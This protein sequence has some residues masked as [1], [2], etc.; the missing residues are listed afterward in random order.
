MKAKKILSVLLFIL[1]VFQPLVRADDF[2]PEEEDGVTETNSNI[3]IL[4]ADNTNGDIQVQFGLALSEYLKWN[5]INARFELSDSLDLLGSELINAR[6]ENLAVA[7]ICD[8]ASKGRMYHD[9]I[10]DHTYVC[11]GTNWVQID[12]GAGGGTV[13]DSTLG[14]FVDT[15]G[16]T[17]INTAAPTAVPFDNEVRKDT[18]ITHDNVTNNTRI[19]LDNAGWYQASYNISY[20]SGDNARKTLRCILQLNGTTMIPGSE[21]FSYSRNNVDKNG[22][23]SA[24]VAFETTGTNEYYE[25][26]CNQ[27]GSAGPVTLTPNGSGTLVQLLDAGS[28]GGGVPFLDMSGTY[29]IAPSTTDTISFYG[30]SFSPNMIVSFPSF[31]G[32]I[33]STNVISPTQVDVNITSTAITGS[34]DVVLDASGTLNTDWPGNGVGKF[35]IQSVS[36]TGPAGTFTTDFTAGGVGSAAWGADWALAVFGPVNSTDGYFNTS[37]AG[38]PSTGTGP[39]AGI[40]GNY[41][42]IEASNTNNG[43]G[44]YGEAFTS[45]F[46][47]ISQIDFDYHMFGANMDRLIVLSQNGDDSWTQ[48]LVLTGSQQAAQADAF[49]PATIDASLWDAKAIKFEFYSE[50]GWSSDTAIDNIVITSN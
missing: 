30:Q 39:T 2:L 17:D 12:G 48:R 36:G 13:V 20:L 40:N 45:N 34:Y 22:S 46:A 29:Q 10:D 19:T 16:G 7:P 3:F 28:G 26:I 18:G 11:D 44:A 14:Q 35:D 15:T 27:A 1:M 37:N 43:A 42:F 50:L 32:T 24:T 4:D 25:I 41:I 49:L 38:T 5:E 33:N 6:V 9:T 21:S 47:S 31:T 8:A 23:N